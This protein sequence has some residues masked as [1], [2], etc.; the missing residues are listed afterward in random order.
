MAIPQ[1]QLETWAKQGAAVGSRD[2]YATVRRALEAPGNGYSARNYKIFLQGSY[3]NDTN[4]WSESDVDIVIRLDSIYFYDT[5]SLNPFHLQQ[6]NATFVPGDYSYGDYKSHV[7][8]ALE[9]AFGKADV[10]DGKKAFKIKPNGNRR[11]ADVLAAALFRRYS[12]GLYGMSIE[13]GICFFNSTGDR[14]VNYPDQHSANCTAKHQSTGGRFKPTVRIFKNMR[15]RLVNEGTIADG[16]APSYYIEGL[17]HNVPNDKFQNS[18]VDTVVDSV[19]WILQANRAAFR[20][21]NQQYLLFGNSAVQWPEANYT[22]FINALIEMWN[23][24]R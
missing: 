4:I 18:L 8:A 6:F 7:K 3:G 2:T 17:L 20:C 14:I 16:I 24:W 22:V 19:T 1:S 13:S 21:A 10:S 15:S 11:S 12:S 9:T 5:S 23:N